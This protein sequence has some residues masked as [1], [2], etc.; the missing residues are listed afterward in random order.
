MKVSE[1]DWQTRDSSQSK[2]EAPATVGPGE[3]ANR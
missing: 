1:N 2:S 3:K